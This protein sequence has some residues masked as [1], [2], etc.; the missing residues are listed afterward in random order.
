MKITSMEILKLKIPEGTQIRPVI[1]KINTDE[2]IYGLG[3]ASVAIVTGAY[4]AAE[5]IKDLSHFIIGENPL[6]HELIWE[7]LFKQSFWGKGNGGVVMAAISAI[8]TALWDI[9]GKYYGVPVYELLGG[10]CRNKLRAYASQLQFGWGEQSMN[11]LGRAEDYAASCKRAVGEGYTAVKA[12]ILQ[13]DLEG[14]RVPFSELCGSLPKKTLSL[15]KERLAAMREAAGDQVDIILE[16]HANTDANTAIQL[17]RMAETY[18]IMFYEEPTLPLN[19]DV[20]KKVAERVGI[21]LA[22]GERTYTRWGFLPLLESGA[23][24]VIQPDIGNCGGVTECKKICDMAH[25]YDVNVQ[26]H[27]C[28]SPLNLAVSLHLEAAI[29]NFIIHEHHM[30][31]TLKSVASQF[32]YDYQ[33]VDGYF[34][35]PDLPGFGQDLSEQAVAE[36][37]IDII[38]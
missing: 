1:C 18:D 28:S 17:G 38:R 22:T 19:M 30:T 5:M 16:N 2:G 34:E 29:P 6:K 23:V 15:A 33:P 24:S 4:A 3:E 20:T 7:R 11:A 36:A 37:Q 14:R 10:K 32:V 31:S 9:K 12:D 25:I 13:F 21:P 27:V 8:D 26:T 35:I